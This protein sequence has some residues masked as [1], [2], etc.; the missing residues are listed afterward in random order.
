MSVKIFMLFVCAAIGTGAGFGFSRMYLRSSA[1][2]SGICELIGELKRSI[3][4]RRDSV[5]SVMK[6]FTSKSDRLNSQIAEYIS[7]ISSK[8]GELRISRGFLS[9]SAYSEVSGF[10]SS[11]GGADGEAQVKDLDR[12]L[13]KF[14][15]DFAAADEKSK[16]YGP[17]AIKLGFLFGL[18]AG[19]LFL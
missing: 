11:L 2:Y 5:V 15:A 16:K 10:F 9:S 8:D 1:Y 7:Y 3:A 12:Y 13:S 6:K 14:E 17:L 4:V 19:I 18:C